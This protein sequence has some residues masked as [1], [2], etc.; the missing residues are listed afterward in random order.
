M[1]NSVMCGDYILAV[2]SKLLAQLENEV[3]EL[4]VYS[5]SRQETVK[6]SRQKIV[7][8]HLKYTYVK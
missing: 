5:R 3:R 7:F 8:H 4:A 2:C 6:R 1:K